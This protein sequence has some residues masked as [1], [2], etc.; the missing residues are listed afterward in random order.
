MK[1]LLAVTLVGTILLGACGPITKENDEKTHKNETK[2]SKNEDGDYNK[3]LREFLSKDIPT[4]DRMFNYMLSSSDET[5]KPQVAIKKYKQYSKE[6]D[7]NLKIHKKNLKNFK[8]NKN[9]KIVG[10]FF[11]TFNEAS[12]THL[13]GLITDLEKIQSG[14]AT[15]YEL[16]E[17]MSNLDNKFTEDVLKANKKFKKI[18]NSELK[19][20]IGNDLY[21]KLDRT[22]NK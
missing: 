19:K 9:E 16:V 1:K 15:A 7:D 6:F 21:K 12:S 2:K 5:A 4:T 17:H 18:P 20:I 11:I 10:D 3:E 14:Q 8:A 13:K 22:L